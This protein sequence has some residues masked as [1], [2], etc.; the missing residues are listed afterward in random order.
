MGTSQSVA[1]AAVRACASK[2]KPYRVYVMLS[3]GELDE[4]SNWEPIIFAPHHDL[5]NLVAIVDYNKIQS[6]GTVAEVLDLHPLAAKWEAC[7]WA[8]RKI[9]GHDTEQIE[10]ALMNLPC[11]PGKPSV[12]IAHTIKGK[13]V[14]FMQDQLAWHY[15]SPSAEQLAHALA[16]LEGQECGAAAHAPYDRPRAGRSGRNAPCDDGDDG[17]ARTVL[18]AAGQSRGAGSA[19]GHTAFRD[20]QGDRDPARRGRHPGQHGGGCSKPC[21]RQPIS[22]QHGD[23]PCVC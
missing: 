12:I 16:E 19:H 18:P 15:K 17:A 5:D 6:F 10:N 21:A 22:W 2:R 4:G 14:S 13:G 11:E 23:C 8:V 9:D 3:D 7:R 20:R 1:P